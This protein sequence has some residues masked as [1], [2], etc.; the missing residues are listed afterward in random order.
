MSF[1]K[2]EDADDEE[3]TVVNKTPDVTSNEPEGKPEMTSAE[4]EDKPEV[5]QKPETV[6]AVVDEIQ[7]NL[8]FPVFNV[9]SN[10][11]V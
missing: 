3:W 5:T 10:A 7:V 1:V 2:K 9:N 6:A 8:A 11:A 4:E